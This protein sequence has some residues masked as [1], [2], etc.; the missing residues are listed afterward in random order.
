MATA[1]DSILSAA[2]FGV[3]GVCGDRHLKTLNAAAPERPR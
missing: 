1:I 2:G 3:T